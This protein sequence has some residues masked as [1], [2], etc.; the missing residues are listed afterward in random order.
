MATPELMAA[1]L[2]VA[3]D[4]EA[5]GLLG[6]DDILDG[7]VGSLAQVLLRGLAGGN[8]VAQ[9]DQVLRTQQ[10]PDVL[11]AEGRGALGLG[12]VES[13]AQCL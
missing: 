12:H 10:A 4:V 5:A 7:R 6:R 13:F 9:L 1:E 3:Q 8:G 2:A 11:S